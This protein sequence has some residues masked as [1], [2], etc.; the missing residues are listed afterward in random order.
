MRQWLSRLLAH[1]SWTTVRDT[2]G[3][4]YQVNERTG[5][6]RIT[7][8]AAGYQPVDHGWLNTGQRTPKR[9]TRPNG[10]D[11]GNTRG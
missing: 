9:P 2:G 3:N 6:R 11:G 8:K 1:F 7:R 4:L 10:Y 5:E